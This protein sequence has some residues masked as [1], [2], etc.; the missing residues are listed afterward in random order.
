MHHNWQ[1]KG[2]RVVEMG[3]FFSSIIADVRTI[4]GDQ[5]TITSR[6]WPW[7]SAIGPQHPLLI[8]SWFGGKMDCSCFLWATRRRFPVND[9]VVTPSINEVHHSQAWSPYCWFQN[10][11]K[12]LQFLHQAPQPFISLFFLHQLRRLLFWYFEI[13]I[14]RW[15]LFEAHN[16]KLKTS[17]KLLI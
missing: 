2:R 12:Q 15:K 8:T 10:V 1:D 3:L 17:I 11:A 7:L 16:F 9:L 6:M 13:H 5:R 4:F 14:F